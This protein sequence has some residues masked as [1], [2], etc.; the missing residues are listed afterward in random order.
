MTLFKRIAEAVA[1]APAEAP[2]AVG[3]AVVDPESLPEVAALACELTVLAPERAGRLLKAL[4]EGLERDT[5]EFAKYQAAELLCAAIYPKYKFSEY[6]RIFLEDEAFLDFYSRSMDPGNWHS[7]DRKYTLN[8]MLKLVA[9]L[10]GDIA[11]CGAYAGVS[12][13]LM[14][15]A[16]E[17]S[18]T[19]V[20]L[21]DSFEGLSEPGDRDGDYW[22]KGALAVSADRLHETLAG[23]ANYRVYKGWIPERFNEVAGCRFRFV[24]IDVDLFQAT[25]D[26]LS[27]FHP[28]M[29]AGGIIL[30]DDYGF[31]SCPGAKAAADAYFADKPERLAM[32]PTGQAFTLKH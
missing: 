2:T 27:F 9:H 18:D 10:T 12:A 23:F 7:L 6:S 15:R 26:S 1:G 17:G 30:L 32:L 13:Y 24:H 29:Q 14:C 28:R 21:F 3:R 25:Y 4:R 16:A 22:V 5:E 20:H 11:E 19:I 8:E 31:K